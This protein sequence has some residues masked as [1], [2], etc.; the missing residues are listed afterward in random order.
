MT[1]KHLPTD[2]GE[3]YLDATRPY[4]EVVEEL[5]L[6]PERFEERVKVLYTE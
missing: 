6:H 4:Q 5:K 3:R 1:P 2:H